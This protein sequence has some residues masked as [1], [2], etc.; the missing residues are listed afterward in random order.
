MEI[1]IF[2]G[3]EYEQIFNLWCQVLGNLW[4]INKE[5]FVERVCKGINF[6][7][8]ENNNIVGFINGQINSNKGQVT[9]IMV[10]DGYK[11]KGIGTLLLNKL[12]KT[13]AQQNI[14]E[15]SVGAGVGTYFWPG[16]PLNLSEGLEFFKKNGLK[17]KDINL[18]MVGNL[19]NYQTPIGVIEKIDNFG[20]TFKTLD[21]EEIGLISNFEKINFPN[22]EKY[23]E[24][25]I[26]NNRLDDIFIVRDKEKILGSTILFSGKGFV[27][28]KLLD[29]TGGFGALG[30]SEDQRGK[31]VGLALA[32]KATEILKQRN[33]KN[34]FLG[35]TYLNKWYGILGYEIWR[36]YEYGK[37]T[38]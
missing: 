3:N 38:H 34:S 37:L 33:V 36:E 6:V 24:S 18:D 12:K 16:V 28:S 4:P 21:S 20:L 13:F 7:A 17:T 25:A 27:W 30:I 23:F 15:I 26:E 1:Q 11:R 32:A 14:K 2:K 31:G 19:T 22:W 10:K 5:E 8:T 35:W 9:L 29:N